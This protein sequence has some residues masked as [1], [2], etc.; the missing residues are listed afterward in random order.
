V[1]L[2][3]VFVFEYSEQ[4]DQEEL[5]SRILQALETIKTDKKKRVREAGFSIWVGR[6][7][8][9]KKTKLFTISISEPLDE[10]IVR[11]F[12]NK[13]RDED[14]YL[15]CSVYYLK[16]TGGEPFARYF[17]GT[18]IVYC[19]P[20]LKKEDFTPE[21]YGLTP[22]FEPR[23][24]ELVQVNKEKEIFIKP[25]LPKRVANFSALSGDPTEKR[26]NLELWQENKEII[27][28]F[29]LNL[30][31]PCG[32]KQLK[33]ILMKYFGI[34]VFEESDKDFGRF[35]CIRLGWMNDSNKSS[36]VRIL[37]NNTLDEKLKYVVLAHELAHYIR[38][39]PL[40]LV[41]QLVEEQAWVMPE[42][43]HYYNYLMSTEYADLP[44]KIE[45]DAF[46][47]ASFFLICPWMHPITKVSSA[48]IERGEHP[49]V[50]ELIWR[51][52]QPYFPQKAGERTSWTNYDNIKN[53]AK[54]DLTKIMK[55]PHG[56]EESLF[57]SY[58]SA[59]LSME[60]RVFSGEFIHHEIEES[61]LEI[62]QKVLDLLTST[63]LMSTPDARNHIK[64]Q[65]KKSVEKRKSAGDGDKYEYLLSEIGFHNKSFG[66]EIVPPLEK[67]DKTHIPRRVPLVP[68]TYNIN[69]DIEGDWLFLEQLDKSPGMTL[70]EWRNHRPQFA[71]VLYRFESWQK[72]MFRKL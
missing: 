44:R 16:D 61:T 6:T 26:H 51:F 60:D 34:G 49:V 54:E 53:R 15:E 9:S 4:L 22:P 30:K 59:S 66:R 71:F 46:E 28:D 11:Q 70:D 35:G 62:Y 17:K 47:V 18:I 31:H 1:E 69:D 13:F 25:D 38:H 67:L 33:N 20:F 7:I 56:N 72:E 23:S 40:L 41:G 63:M 42:I 2:V 5:K 19:D 37:I 8:N 68:A 36:H 14:S 58:Y 45:Q 21:K 29:L 48:V 65:L 10:N 64:N 57:E 12:Y 3:R 27:F 24:W 39:F 52:L 32:Y 55:S 43:E 50:H